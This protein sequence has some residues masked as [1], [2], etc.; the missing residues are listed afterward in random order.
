MPCKCQ[1]ETHPHAREYMTPIPF[2]HT[3]HDIPHL[4]SCGT[5]TLSFPLFDTPGKLD[6][7]PPAGPER[8]LPTARRRTNKQNPPLRAI[9]L[10]VR[11]LVA[12]SGA[13]TTELLGLAAAV[14]GDEEGA[15]KLDEGLLEHVLGVLVDELL[16]VGDEGLGD[17]L[18]DGVDLRSLTTASDAD[19][20]V[21]VGELVEADNQ[22]RLV[23]LMQ[24]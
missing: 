21:D 12:G 2:D 24:S 19:T 14:V 7:S 6:I 18:T 9:R 13:G 1:W 3:C 11:L 16:V 23:D 8:N 5:C 17:G 4:G 15:V 20:D 22:E 10:S